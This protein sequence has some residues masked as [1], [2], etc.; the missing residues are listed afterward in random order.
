MRAAAIRALAQADPEGFVTVLSGLDPD[1]HWSVRAALA[2]VLGTLSPE[3]GLPR[4]RAM[5][6]DTDERVIPAVLASLAKLHAP[7]AAAVMRERLAASDPVIRAAAATALGELAPCPPAVRQTL[8]A[9]TTSDQRSVVLAAQ[10]AR[11]KCT[12]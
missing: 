10:R 1:R 8:D 6:Q 5:L 7:D 11:V 2:S 9:L 4:L 12:R 3:A